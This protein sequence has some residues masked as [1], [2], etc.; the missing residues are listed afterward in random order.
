MGLFFK[1]ASPNISAGVIAKTRNSQAGEVISNFPKSLTGGR[2]LNLNDLH[3]NGL[4]IKVMW[5]NS[6]KV[7]LIKWTK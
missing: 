4:K 2:V 6:N 5:F 3:G 7:F 1:I